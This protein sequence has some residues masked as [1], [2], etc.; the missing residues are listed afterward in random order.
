MVG[1]ALQAPRGVQP[2]TRGG[3]DTWDRAGVEGVRTASGWAACF[4]PEVSSAG[5]AGGEKPIKVTPWSG[6]TPGA[7][8]WLR[9]AAGRQVPTGPLSPRDRRV[10]AWEPCPCGRAC[11]LDFSV[12]TVFTS[13]NSDNQSSQCKVRQMHQEKLGQKGG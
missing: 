10:R 3:K 1:D 12:T 13:L 11:P 8:V 7:G 6:S 4:V 9:R 2:G 5:K